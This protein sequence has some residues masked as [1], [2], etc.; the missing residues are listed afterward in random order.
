MLR[1]ALQAGCLA[2]GARRAVD[3]VRGAL[4]ALGMANDCVCRSP[5]R[6]HAVELGVMRQEGGRS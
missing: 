6:L 3:C 4:S 1:G 2:H 5:V